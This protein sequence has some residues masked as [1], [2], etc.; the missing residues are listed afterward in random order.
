MIMFDVNTNLQQETY[1]KVAKLRSRVF[2]ISLAIH[3]KSWAKRESLVLIG[4]LIIFMYI[5]VFE[6]FLRIFFIAYSR[7]VPYHKISWAQ[8]IFQSNA[9]VYITF[10]RF[11]LKRVEVFYFYK[12][13]D[14]LVKD[15]RWNDI[16]LFPCE[17][18]WECC[19]TIWLMKSP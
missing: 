2:A 6:F 8:G 13:Y 11:F 9:N 1:G 3:F 15:E 10:L 16:I 12:W 4:L 18:P 5:Y 19:S 7:Y 14:S 17:N